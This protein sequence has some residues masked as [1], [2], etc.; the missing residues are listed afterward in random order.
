MTLDDIITMASIIAA[1]KDL[2][3][4]KEL[5]EFSE[6]WRDVRDLPL[7]DLLITEAPKP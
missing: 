7:E 3:Q 4:M 1:F 5:T 2:E 6:R